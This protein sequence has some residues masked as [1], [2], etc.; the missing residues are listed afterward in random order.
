MYVFMICRRL[1]I[2]TH[3][4]CFVVDSAHTNR[5][6]FMKQ[7]IRYC[8][9][10]ISCKYVV[11]PGTV[12]TVPYAYKGR[13]Q[14]CLLFTLCERKIAVP[15]AAPSSLS[16]LCRRRDCP[17]GRSSGTGGSRSSRRCSSRSVRRLTL[18]AASSLLQR[19]I[20]LKVLSV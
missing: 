5:H 15:L 18:L 13:Y 11:N 12:P 9:L 1:A 14:V 19:G 20:S 8:L 7:F 2:A 3:S 17:S 10:M 16:P 4:L 6:L